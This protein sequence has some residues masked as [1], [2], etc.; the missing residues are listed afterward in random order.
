MNRRPSNFAFTL[1]ELILVLAILAIVVAV[2]AP[3]FRNFT[4]GRNTQNTAT[5]ILAMTNYARSQAIT[6]GRSYR[7][8]YDGD[9]RSL[10]LSAGNDGTSSPTGDFGTPLVIADGITIDTDIPTQDT[11]QYVEFHP[12]GR[13]DPATIH[14][15][16]RF[17]TTIDIACSSATEMFRILPAA[18]VGR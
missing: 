6:Q 8:N 11:G 4:A 15:S 14:L 3:N 16:D 18:E 5:H 1:I 13:T 9:A 10:W 12:S 17:G 7:L 2:V